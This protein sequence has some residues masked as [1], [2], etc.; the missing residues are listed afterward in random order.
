MDAVL[1]VSRDFDLGLLGRRVAARLIDAFVMFNLFGLLGAIGWSLVVGPAHCEPRPDCYP[2][3]IEAM[4]YISIGGV[5]LVLG[6]LSPII[7]E[8]ACVAWWK[9]TIGKALLGLQVVRTEGERAGWRRSFARIILLWIA[10]PIPLWTAAIGLSERHDG[11]WEVLMLVL[12]VAWLVIVVAVSILSRRM[13]HDLLADT[14]VV[15]KA[16]A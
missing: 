9:R 1:T 8:S 14:Q 5:M 15:R 2:A 4:A 11:P 6:L 7:Y 13:F 10:L 16:Q 12:S 3:N